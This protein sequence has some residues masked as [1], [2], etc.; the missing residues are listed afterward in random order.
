[1]SSL[2]TISGAPGPRRAD[3][4]KAG[5]KPNDGPTMNAPVDDHDR[6]C[7]RVELYQPA[8]KANCKILLAPLVGGHDG[9]DGPR[10][11]RRLDV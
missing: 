1:M 7:R 6:A 8:R 5:L 4:H 11:S 10:P 9:K 2:V 3:F